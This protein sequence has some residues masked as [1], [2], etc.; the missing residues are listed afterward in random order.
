MKFGPVCGMFALGPGGTRGAAVPDVVFYGGGG[1][2][3]V[4]IITGL[5]HSPVDLSKA[6]HT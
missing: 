6:R 4:S 5:K 3:L 1:H 2:H